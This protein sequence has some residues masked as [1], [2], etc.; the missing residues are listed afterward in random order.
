MVGGRL[1]HP[2]TG[3]ALLELG[4]LLLE[5][6][7]LEAAG[8]CFYD[9]TFPAAL[10]GQADVL[11]EAFALA[12]Q[13]HVRTGGEQ[14]FPPLETAAAWAQSKGLDRAAAS[15]LLSAGENV[16]LLNA[17]RDADR[18]LQRAR[19]AMG[20]VTWQSA[21]SVPECNTFAHWR[22]IRWGKHRPDAAA[23]TSAIKLQTRLSPRLFQIRLADEMY[24]TQ[25]VSPRVA[26]LLYSNVLRE[27]TAA[28]WKTDP[29]NNLLVQL[30]N[31]QVPYDHWLEVVIERRDFA[32]LVFVSEM[33][34]RQKFFRELPLGGRLLGLRWLL[35]A[36]PVV[37]DKD[38]QLQREDLFTR[39]PQLNELSRSVTQTKQAWRRLPAFPENSEQVRQSV[40][41]AQQ[42]TRDSQQQEQI[43][44]EIALRPEAASRLFPP[45]LGLE[46][47]Q[48]RLQP[49]QTI[50]GFASTG[51]QVH[52]LLITAGQRYES[53]P[54]NDLPQFRRGI[55]ELVRQIGNYDRGQVLN[56]AL[57]TDQKWKDTAATLYQPLATKLT[58]EILAET[59][60]L[61]VVPDGFLWYLPFELLQV[62]TARGR[63]ALIDLTP[64][65][66]AP[67]LGLAVT[68]PRP[69]VGGGT[70]A[71]VAGRLFG[72]ETDPLVATLASE[73]QQLR[74]KSVL[75][76]TPLPAPSGVMAGNWDGL[77]VLDDLD[78][79]AKS[80]LDWVPAAID[81]GRPNSTLREWL[82][83]PWEGPRQLILPGF[84]TA[85]ESALRRNTSGDEIFLSVCGLMASGTRS[86]LL[87][88]WRS[89]GRT[90]L[91]MI[92]EFVQELP[93]ETPAAAWQR[94]ILLARS[95]QLD[96]TAEPRLKG[97]TEGQLPSADHPF[98][99]GGY[100]LID[101]SP[102]LADR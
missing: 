27:P 52:A 56:A 43:L 22:P 53:W 32:K 84:P 98:F 86:V 38:S 36:D 95:A 15:I 31:T 18:W 28:D 20:A 1:D 5:Q 25:A 47:L 81:R 78:D 65:R 85:V 59:R 29:L 7:E 23:L 61:V 9:A 93:R 89:G 75:L 101:S 91:E 74:P 6:Q 77:I 34:R 26:D 87:S 42:M 8:R 68:D 4:K 64:I 82:E 54:L 49:G 70:T 92:R 19:R 40:Q 83:L 21:G 39:F 90:S 102:P 99:W 67:T 10:F 13:T 79:V 69:P 58:P 80:P 48:A 45:L 60:E 46:Q 12:T 14:L 97:V 37:L 3:V 30:T 17:T 24:R 94:A 71:I 16:L 57:L 33:V 72:P 50:L 41:F 62:P 51:Q 96:P 35:E 11:E 76:K 100:L 73:L 2:L 55:V 44:A 66:Y 88:R 63:Q